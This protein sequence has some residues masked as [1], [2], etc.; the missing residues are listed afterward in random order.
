EDTALVMQVIAGHDPRDPT[1][2]RRSVPDHRAALGAGVRG[3]RIGV[4]RELVA[5]PDVDVEVRDGLAAA[6]DV[7]KGL[8]AT[9]E[10]VS[11]PLLPL[12][13]GGFTTLAGSDACAL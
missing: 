9:V 2:S 6:L 5:S 1:T 10:E 11:L 4:A 8:G 13:G 12:A 3:L 7:L